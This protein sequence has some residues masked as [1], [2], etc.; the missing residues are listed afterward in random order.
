MKLYIGGKWSDKEYIR[1]IMDRFV[2]DGSEITH[3]WTAVETSSIEER[4]R[5]SPA[6]AH[7]DRRKCADLDIKGVQDADVVMLFMT[8]PKYPYRG[9]FTELGA[10]I[11]LKKPTYI[12]CPE[13]DNNTYECTTN[14]FFHHSSIIHCRTLEELIEHYLKL[15]NLE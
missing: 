14:C 5:M 8:D 1:S 9:T 10:A 6:D 13:Y 4:K 2:A 12:V 3:D 11:G 15:G 7:N